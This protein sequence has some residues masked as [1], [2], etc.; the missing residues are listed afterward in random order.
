LPGQG[1]P[2]LRT[3]VNVGY[4]AEFRERE[5]NLGLLEKIA[6]GAPPGGEPGKLIRDPEQTGDI[7]ALVDVAD[8]FRHDLPAATSREPI[9]HLFAL[10]AGC[11][12]FADVFVR[13]VAISFE[14]ITP[15]MLHLRD[16][17]LRRATAPAAPVHLDRLRVRKA[18]V[19][20][21]IER[22]REAAEVTNVGGESFRRSAE[23]EPA[24]GEAS[25][26]ETSQKLDAMF[27]KP[28]FGRSDPEPSPEEDY[29]AR[30]KKAK[31]RALEDRDEK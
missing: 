10:V 9:W 8:T 30:L 22:R 13:R 12:F 15:L 1:Q 6:A 21:Q 14:W 29:A 18:E 4:A 24:I 26:K 25:D 5:A 27:Q 7:A 11:L 20:A 16:R 17:M 31:R 2:M 23:V 3:G 19:G 28:E